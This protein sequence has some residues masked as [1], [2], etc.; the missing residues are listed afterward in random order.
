[1]AT[2]YMHADVDH[3]PKQIIMVGDL[4]PLFQE[5]CKHAL[6]LGKSLMQKATNLRLPDERMKVGRTVQVMR[7][8]QQLTYLASALPG[9]K[10]RTEKTIA[11]GHTAAAQLIIRKSL[12]VEQKEATESK[13]EKYSVQVILEGYHAN[14]EKEA[15][16]KRVAAAEAARKEEIARAKLARAAARVVPIAQ[17]SSGEPVTASPVRAFVPGPAR[18]LDS[19]LPPSPVRAFVPGVARASTKTTA[20]KGKLGLVVPKSA[21]QRRK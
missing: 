15:K 12:K 14:T 9:P 1:M 2:A 7:Q 18:Q 6:K 4:M 19:L 10:S 13:I 3:I 21:K 20:K 5:A 11:K 17:G 16:A 8:E